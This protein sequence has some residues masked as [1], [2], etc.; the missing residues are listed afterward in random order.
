MFMSHDD[1]YLRRRYRD[2]NHI[3]HSYA[4]LDRI[5]AAARKERE[6]SREKLE[7]KREDGR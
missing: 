6:R 4:P 7:R 2:P 5:E 1:G 3:T